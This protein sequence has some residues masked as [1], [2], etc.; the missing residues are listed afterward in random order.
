MDFFPRSFER[1]SH[2]TNLLF[3][4]F[5]IPDRRKYRQKFLYEDVIL[6][7]RSSGFFRRRSLSS[8]VRFRNRGGEHR[9]DNSFL[10]AV[11]ERIR[12]SAYVEPSR[13]RCGE[14]AAGRDCANKF[15]PPRLG[16]GLGKPPVLSSRRES[17]DEVYRLG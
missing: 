5:H 14:R 4:L 15:P 16:S 12:D 13:R 7:S 8:S 10:Q 17:F 3:Y 6:E 2:Y 11:H 9:T 1:I